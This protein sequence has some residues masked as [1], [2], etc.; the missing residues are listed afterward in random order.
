MKIW[1]KTKKVRVAKNVIARKGFFELVT[2]LIPY[3]SERSKSFLDIFKLSVFKED[4]GM[5][6]YV[7]DGS[8]HSFFMS[9]PIIVVFLDKKGKVVDIKKL[10]P[11]S[12]VKCEKE[13]ECFLELHEIKEKVIDVGDY[14]VLK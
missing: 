2:G 10:K 1:N 4:D 5:L 7:K 14:L 11:F 8:V 9:F 13:F 12:F 6:F 3:K